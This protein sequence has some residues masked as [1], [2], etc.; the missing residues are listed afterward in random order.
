MEQLITTVEN[1]EVNTLQVETN[2]QFLCRV[3]IPA[4][5][6]TY[7][8]VAHKT[9]MDLT[10]DAIES[11]GF[12]LE[13]EIYTYSKDGQ[14]ANGKY[15]LKY[16]NDSE[17]SLMIAW[18]N[19]YD[20]SLSL[21]F[22]IGT[23]VFICENGCVS[24][25]MGAFKSKHVG[26]VQ[27]V[28]P[29]SIKDYICGAGDTFYRMVDA[30]E[31]MKEIQLSKQQVAE[32]LGRMFVEKEIIIS[33]QLNTIKREIDK[34]TYEYGAPGTLWELYNHITFSLKDCNPTYW[35]ETQQKSH[36]FITEE[37]NIA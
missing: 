9:L 15:L 35:L 20:K 28:T 6:S 26:D 2:K 18:Q 17:M 5:T 7:K 19:S 13:K 21:K 31:A 24:G 29:Q 27:E 3:V 36:Q 37:F 11:C 23:W 4:Q 12:Q 34:P 32:L 10:L 25:N 22:A 1:G 16:G 14:R 33:T 8:P 30:K